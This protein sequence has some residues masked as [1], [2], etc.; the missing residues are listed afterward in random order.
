VLNP[1]CSG[2]DCGR[3]SSCV[4][5]DGRMTCACPSGFGYV[6]GFGCRPDPDPCESAS[7]SPTEVC[8]GEHHCT[9]DAV[10]VPTCDC[11]NCGNCE[12]DN[13]DGRWDDMVEHCGNPG[14]SPATATCAL[15]CPRGHGCIPY[16]PP[17]CWPMQGCMSM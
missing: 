7:C 16:S 11:S 13:S 10:C 15:P 9:A 3:C 1:T 4:D 6:A 17:I 2:D 5:I 14:S 8:V 12:L